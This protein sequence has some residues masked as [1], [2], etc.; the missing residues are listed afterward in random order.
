M[1]DLLPFLPDQASTIAASVDGL[2]L[3]LAGVSAFL[4]VLIFTLVFVFAVKYRRRS[5]SETPRPILGSAAL[6]AVWIVIPFFIVMV[7]FTWGA[8]LYIQ[9]SRVPAGAMEIYVTGKQWMWKFQHPTGQREINELHVPVGRPIRLIVASEDVIHSLYIP[10]FRVKQD[11]VPG[12]YN[13]LW[14]EAVRTGEYHLFCAEYCGTNHSKMTGR[15][16]A[17]EPVKYQQWLQGTV[18]DAETPAAGGA[19]LFSE[20]GCVTCHGSAPARQRGAPLQGLFGNEVVLE[21]GGTVIADEDYL[22][23]SIL[24]PQAKIVRGYQPIMPPYQGQVTEEQLLQL[25]AFIKS[26]SSEQ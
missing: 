25:I 22:R 14:F 16:F 20:L 21:T 11:V 17:M 2:F 6:E 23:E 15:V 18:Q 3:F 10:A 8:N 13:S 1:R 4:T 26:L 7:M 5:E 19:R 24:R 9:N 12:T